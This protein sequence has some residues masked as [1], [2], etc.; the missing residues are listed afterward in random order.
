MTKVQ[1]NSMLVKQYLN[2]GATIEV[3]TVQ[4]VSKAKDTYGYNILTAKA[5]CQDRPVGDGGKIGQCKGGGYDMLGTC[6]AQFLSEAYQK[7]LVAMK[8]KLLQMKKQNNTSYAKAFNYYTQSKK[9]YIEGGYGYNVVLQYLA[10]LGLTYKSTTTGLLI[11]KKT[12]N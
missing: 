6:L 11:K 4:T 3:K 10:I 5:Y 9:A 12:T 8:D 7:E 1:S 2:Q